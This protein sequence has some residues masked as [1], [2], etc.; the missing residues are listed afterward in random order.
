MPERL[1]SF[2]GAVRCER[3]GHAPGLTLRGHTTETESPAEPASFAFSGVAPADLPETLEDALVEHLEGQQYRIAD[4]TRTWIIT[5]SAVHLHREIAPAFYRA[6]P[7]RRPP[8]AK[9]AFL[10]TVL[11]LAA[12]RL[13][14]ALL[15]AARR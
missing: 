15:R 6:I 7:P 5:A 4:R 3:A 11:A 9:R 10:R 12:S 8:W 2:R 13:G 1:A 14:L